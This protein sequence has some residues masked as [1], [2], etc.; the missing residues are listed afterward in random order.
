MKL[1]QRIRNARLDRL[2]RE[3]ATA[4]DEAV[5][6]ILADS[7]RADALVDIADTRLAAYR[8]AITSK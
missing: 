6:A 7:P 4:V 2:Q 3:A 8:L 1:S 5:R